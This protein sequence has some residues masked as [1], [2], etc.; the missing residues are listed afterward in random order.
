MTTQSECGEGG[1]PQPLEISDEDVYEAMNKIPGYL[2]ITPGNFKIAC[3]F[4]YNF[5]SSECL[6]FLLHRQGWEA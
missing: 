5:V 6:P 2:D 1:I 3:I 4:S